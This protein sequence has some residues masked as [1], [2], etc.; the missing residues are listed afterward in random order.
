MRGR[1]YRHL[2]TKWNSL[3]FSL[4]EAGDIVLCANPHDV[5]AMRAVLF[6]SH[7]GIYT[8]LPDESR[9]FVDAVN[10]PVR[11]RGRG[12]LPWQR[13]RFTSK[14]MYASYVDILVLRPDCPREKRAAAAAYAIG[15]VG[16]P[17][18]RW[19]LVGFLKIRDEDHFTCASLVYQAYRVQGVDLAPRLFF[20]R[21][22]PWPSAMAKHPHIRVVAAGTRWRPIPLTPANW[23]IILARLWFRYARGA[24]IILRFE[25]GSR[26]R[27]ERRG[28]AEP[29]GDRPD[30]DGTR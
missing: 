23:K 17:F 12:K 11:D 29:G 1:R 4:L 10:L 2:L 24:P 13:V 3:D 16:K 19:L 5:P 15:K 27:A 30:P 7:A 6:W 22:V 20:R 18:H 21:V 25:R 8:G 14:R 28:P 26:S 9:A